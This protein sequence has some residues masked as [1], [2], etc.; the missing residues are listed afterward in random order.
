MRRI[1]FL[2]ILCLF[3]TLA[4]SGCGA[5]GDSGSSDAVQDQATDTS[6]DKLSSDDIVPVTGPGWY[7]GD[8][9]AHST[10][11][12][13]DVSVGDVVKI[14]EAKGLNFFTLTDHMHGE[15]GNV[16]KSW[17][18]IGYHSSK[19]TLLY[20][21]EWTTGKGHANVW[22]NKR[23]DW[24]AL[25]AFDKAENV[26]EA[27]ATAHSFRIEGQEVLFSINHPTSSWEYS[28]EDSSEADSMEIWNSVIP[29]PD[30]IDGYYQKGKR[31]TAVGGSDSHDHMAEYKE[32][33]DLAANVHNIGWPTTWVYAESSSA[34]DILKGIRAG[35]TAV[36]ISPDGPFLEFTA[37]ADNDGYY[38][39]MTGN[40]IPSDDFGKDVN[41]KIMVTNNKIISSFLTVIKNGIM[42]KK[43][44][45][46]NDIYIFEFTDKPQASDYYR[47]Q[48]G[49]G[50]LP[51]GFTS[52]IFTW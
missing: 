26:K 25:Y 15:S 17:D 41:F 34:F 49:N 23:F 44:W 11:S 9:H 45:C 13:G 48:I 1:N 36:S 30:F 12:D 14:A 52:P 24:E 18:D 38:E 29:M 21:A 46:A 3:F 50:I 40:T 33:K 43:T 51:L 2:F 47:V 31:I 37:D 27:I 35:R 42:F 39:L 6:G 19:L 20:G 8:L 32:I 4:M 28:F 16:T 7:K 22:S 5:S 10:Y